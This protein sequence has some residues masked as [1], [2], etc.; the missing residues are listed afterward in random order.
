MARS[1]MTSPDGIKIVKHDFS[2]SY[3]RDWP[4]S[5]LKAHLALDYVIPD[6]A[7][8]IFQAIVDRYRAVRRKERLKIVDVGCSYGINAALLR[9]DMNLDDLYAAYTVGKGPLT[10]RHKADHRAFFG[11]RDAGTDLRFI[12]VDPSERAARYARSVGLVDAI[13][14]SDLEVSEPTAAER[15]ALEGADIIISTGCVGYATERTFARVYEA[16]AI[17]RPWV[18]AFVMHPYSYHG[19]AE[20]LATFGLQ[21]Q[22]CFVVRQRRFSTDAERYG[23]LRAMKEQGLDPRLEHATGYIYASFHL[24]TLPNEGS[25]GRVNP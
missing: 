10:S 6:Q 5:Y 24:S 18:A 17:S 4:H 1:G 20:T 15:R 25:T 21:T 12:G 2:A 11:K 14:T 7:K 9:T 3:N 22:E 13:V 19:I 16:A 23:L 8:P